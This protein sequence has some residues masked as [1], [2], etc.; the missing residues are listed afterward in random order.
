MAACG[1]S[2]SLFP[3]LHILRGEMAFGGMLDF[4]RPA[5]NLAVK[6]P[7]LLPDP[8]SLSPAPAVCP[9]LCTVWP[10]T[11]ATKH[12]LVL[13]LLTVYLSTCPD[14]SCAPIPA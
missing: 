7:L 6:G 5:L 9:L 10:L 1:Y 3:L 2:S 12:R 8:Q 4:L 13:F 11:P 14:S